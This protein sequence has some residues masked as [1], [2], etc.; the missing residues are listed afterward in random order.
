MLSIE[1]KTECRDLLEKI[2]EKTNEIR[3]NHLQGDEIIN[4]AYLFR[5]L[6]RDVLT[7]RY[8]EPIRYTFWLYLW[9]ALFYFTEGQDAIPDH[10]PDGFT[11]DMWAFSVVEIKFA[12]ELAKYKK[13]RPAN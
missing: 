3:D 12:E 11:D 1:N 7:E 6:L 4:Q 9:A 13:F 10:Q 2:T 8:L 5:D